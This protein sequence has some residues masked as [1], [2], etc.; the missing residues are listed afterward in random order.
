MNIKLLR[1]LRYLSSLTGYW[2]QYFC[3]AT[4]TSV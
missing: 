2:F 3:D 4:S 1:P